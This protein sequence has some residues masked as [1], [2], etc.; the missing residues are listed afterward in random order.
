MSHNV[1][2][3]I[4]TPG[5]GKQY[6]RH[7]ATAGGLRVMLLLPVDKITWFPATC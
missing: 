7:T 5:V 2:D 4:S 3:Q 1:R 6:M